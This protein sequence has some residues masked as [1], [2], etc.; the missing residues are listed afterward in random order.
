MYYRIVRALHL[1]AFS[2]SFDASKQMKKWSVDDIVI[3][4]KTLLFRVCSQG[5]ESKVTACDR[6][7]ERP[8]EKGENMTSITAET[9]LQVK[10]SVLYDEQ[11]SS[12]GITAVWCTVVLHTEQSEKDAR[13]FPFVSKRKRK[14][15]LIVRFTIEDPRWC[16]P[17]FVLLRAHL[18]IAEQHRT[19]HR[20]STSAIVLIPLQLGGLRLEKQQ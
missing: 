11:W 3:R 17:A 12:R 2:G 20:A 5:N 14:T 16:P 8:D 9:Q 4:V 15:A 18:A 13:S 10:G 1:H 19:F 7:D 6:N